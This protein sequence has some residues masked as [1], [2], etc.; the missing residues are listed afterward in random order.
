MNRIEK[1]NAQA[2]E[3]YDKFNLLLPKGE[4]ERITAAAASMNMSVSKYIQIL[5]SN[6]LATGSS[7]L[8]EKSVEFTEDQFELL[9]KWQIPRKYYEMIERMSYD[10]KEGYMIA[11][12]DGYVNEETGSRIITA[13]RTAEIRKYIVKSHKK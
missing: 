9:E 5:I 13:Q 10:K 8:A 7:K 11:L 3:N 1:K 4:K 12:K 6:D 2:K